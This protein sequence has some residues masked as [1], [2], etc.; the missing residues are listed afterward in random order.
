[1]ATDKTDKKKS[2]YVILMKES[3]TNVPC[4]FG[5]IEDY[6]KDG[7][8]LYKIFSFERQSINAQIVIHCAWLKKKGG[9]SRYA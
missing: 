5:D 6:E 8:E 9:G 7:Y 1:M 2:K 4:D 3:R